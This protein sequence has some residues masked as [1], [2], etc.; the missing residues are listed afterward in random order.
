MQNSAV[1][2]RSVARIIQIFSLTIKVSVRW[3]SS[4]TIL[5]DQLGDAN[6]GM[7]VHAARQSFLVDLERAAV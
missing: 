2:Y 6:R 1:G 3:A 4:S 7:M 5:K